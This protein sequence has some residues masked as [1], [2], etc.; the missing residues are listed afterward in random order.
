MEEALKEIGI[1]ILTTGG[2]VL[3]PIGRLNEPIFAFL[4]SAGI[5]VE[6]V[7]LLLALALYLKIEKLIRRLEDE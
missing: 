5:W 1:F 6:I 7:W 4:F 3:S 2:G